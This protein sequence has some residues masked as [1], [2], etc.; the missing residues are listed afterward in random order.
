MTTAAT[1]ERDML[2]RISANLGLSYEE[3]VAQ[4]FRPSDEV[5]LRHENFRRANEARM[6]P[7]RDAANRV[8]MRLFDRWRF[9]QDDAFARETVLALYE[10]YL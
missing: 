10:R 1:F 5:R 8:V 3:L 9:Q 2:Q 4:D 6:R 7:F